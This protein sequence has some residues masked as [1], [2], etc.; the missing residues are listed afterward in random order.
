MIQREGLAM[1]RILIGSAVVVSLLSA[2][3]AFA[4][5]L[6]ARPYTKAPVYVDPGYN[7]TGFYVGLNG[8]YSWGRANT[9]IAPFP[10][11]PT[12]A[13]AGHHSVDGGL[14][15]GQIG[16]NWQVDRKW[17]I[18]LEADIQGTGERSSSLLTTVGPRYGSNI[19]GIPV[20]AGPDFNAIVTQTANLAHDLQWFA[21]FRGR[22]GVLA[23]PQTLL[24]ATGGL[25]VGEFKYSAQTTTSIQVFTPGLGGTTPVGPPLVLAGAAA[26]SSDTR[27]GWT[28]GAG[29]ERKFS[30]NWSGKLEYLYLDF[31]SKTYFA[32]TVNQADVSFHDHVFRAGI[33]YAFNAAPIVAKY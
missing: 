15:G 31:G 10:I 20:A 3:G 12:A 25:A 2:T 5:D 13:L 19:I 18:G 17:V 6:A 29:V 32:G 33:N 27:V 28:V 23:D 21:T 26:S 11:F 7:W 30:A 24:Y 1:K 22:A 4:A 9:T 16:Y 8:G 14:G